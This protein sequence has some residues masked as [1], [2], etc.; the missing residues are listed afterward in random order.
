MLK[1]LIEHEYPENDLKSIVEKY[2]KLNLVPEGYNFPE[3]QR[4]E[5]LP[6]EMQEMLQRKAKHQQ[7][8]Q[9]QD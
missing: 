9:Q 3:L 1:G 5:H 6:Q 8:Q 7:E 4:K 2:Q